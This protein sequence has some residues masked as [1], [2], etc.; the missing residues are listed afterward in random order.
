MFKYIK[1]LWNTKCMKIYDTKFQN[2]RAPLNFFNQL[3]NKNMVLFDKFCNSYRYL[4]KCVVIGCYW[5]GVGVGR[6][7]ATYK[8]RDEFQPITTHFSR[9]LTNK[10]IVK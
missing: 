8:S 3:T 7:V 6:N 1:K 10:K 2:N 9:Y 4:A 5:S